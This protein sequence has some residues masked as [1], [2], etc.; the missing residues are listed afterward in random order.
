MK[1]LVTIVLPAYNASEYLAETLKSVLQ[2][3][4]T[5]FELLVIDD[6]STDDTADI[7]H[8]LS[9]QDSRVKLISQ[10]NQGV[11]V[12]RN[13]G[14]NMAQGEFIAFLDADDLW[15]PN[16]LT[17]HIQHL[18][19]NPNLG[20]SFARVEFMTFDGK[21]TGKYSNPHFRNITQKNLY[22]ENPA[23]TPS[24]AVF[25]R[26]ALQQVGGFDGDLSGVADAELFLRIKC[27]GWEVEGIDE[28]LVLYR[29]SLAGM[30]SQL[31]KME[32]DWNRF[33]NKVQAYAPELIKHHYKYS[34]AMLL[35]YL[36]RRTLRLRLPSKVGVSFMNRALQSEWTLILKEPR[37][38]LLTIIAV[39]GKYLIPSFRRNYS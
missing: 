33:S 8:N 32:E 38:T 25:R 37:R 3:T 39:Y 6:G 23:I 9:Q 36:A 13:I 21:A 1:I 5:N 29:T 19:A 7:V 22:E 20:L 35:R 16:K 15:L 14:I 28:V 10:Q 34:K 24:N 2:Q 17:A 27:H 18:S 26:I 12:A 4:Y 30:S 11:S 31:Y